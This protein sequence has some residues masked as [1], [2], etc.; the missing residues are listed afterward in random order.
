[1]L[2]TINVRLVRKSFYEKLVTNQKKYRDYELA[3]L[4]DKSYVSKF[5]E[6]L[7]ESKS[8]LRQDLFVLSELGFKHDGYFVEFGATNGVDLSNSYLLETK[9]NWKGIL[10]EP[11]KIWHK[12]LKINRKVDIETDCVWKTSGDKLIFNEV[13]D[14]KYNGEL[15]TIDVF[16][17]SDGHSK[18]RKL[19][20][21]YEVKTISL[22]DLLTKYN[23]PKQIDFLSIDTEGSEFEILSAFDFSSYD[24]KVITCEHNFTPMRQKLYELLTKNGYERKF[25]EYSLFDDWYVLR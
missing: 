9:F 5:F 14:D 21:K 13:N 7:S 25:S 4:I 8:Q 17:D 22:A 6:Y 15:S 12:E 19:G 20:K 23:A 11:A 1:M 3:D 16:S 10:A 2:G 24:I 18:H